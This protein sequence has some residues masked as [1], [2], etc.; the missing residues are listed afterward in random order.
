MNIPRRSELSQCRQP[1]ILPFH[2]HLHFL[3]LIKT[4]DS[5]LLVRYAMK[6]ITFSLDAL[7]PRTS[8]YNR[9]SIK[10][11]YS[12]LLLTFHT[13]VNSDSVLKMHLT[14]LILLSVMLFYSG[15]EGEN[16]CVH[17]LPRCFIV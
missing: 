10:K 8:F 7:L 9:F 5:L 17:D 2:D 14:P 16:E 12:I 3:Y 11:N 4:T 1:H 6:Q 13:K 15:I